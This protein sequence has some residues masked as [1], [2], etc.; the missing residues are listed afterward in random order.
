MIC[1]QSTHRDHNFMKRLTTWPLVCGALALLAVGTA[2]AADPYYINDGVVDYPGNLA[3]PPTIDATN[4]I[5]NNSF[6]INFTSLSVIPPYYEMFDTVNYTNTGLMVANSGYHFD[7]QIGSTGTHLMAGSFFNSGTISCGSSTDTSDPLLGEFAL[8]GFDQCVVNATNI[9]NPG[10]IDVGGGGLIK[11]TGLN[12]DLSGSTLTVEG[13]PLVTGYGVYNVN[14][15]TWSPFFELNGANNTSG[16]FGVPPFNLF[17]TTATTYIDIQTTQ[18]GYNVIRAV[19]IQDTSTN[20][21]TS[22]YFEPLNF[23]GSGNAI[24]QW[25]GSYLNS[26]DGN[27]D[28]T[29]LYLSD[30]Y[31][32]GASTNVLPIITVPFNF[33]VSFSGI[34]LNLGPPASSGFSPV[35]LRGPVTNA[36]DFANI[37]LQPGGDTNTIPNYSVT[38]LPGRI[39]ITGATNLDLTLAQLTGLSYMSIQSPY[40]FNGSAGALIQTP[41]ADLNLGVT[42]GFL[43]VS[44]TMES[45]VPTWVGNIQA[46]NTRWLAVDPVTGATNDYRVLMVNSLLQPT[47][48]AQVQDL[49]LHGTN[50]IIISDTFNV[51]RTFT[52]DAQ[53][54]TVTTNPPGNGATS[55]EGEL[56]LNSPTIFWQSSV[57]N[58]RYL[59]NNGAIRMGNSANFGHPLLTNI[60]P[61]VAASGML[62][63]TGTNAVKKDKVTIGTIQYLFVG[64]LT[65]SVANEVLI[66]PGSFDGTVS[67]LIAAINATNGAGSS[68]STAT[69]ANPVAVAG[70]LINH[71]FTVTA[72]N[73]GTAGNTISTMFTPAT[74]SINLSWQG[75][76]DLYGGLGV[77]TNTVSFLYNTAFI[78]NGIF[79]DYGAMIYAGNFISSDFFSNSVGS[80][81]LQ[82]LTTT[83]TN[84]SLY[85]G[86]DVSI[87]ASNIVTSNL[88]M[89]AGRS[90]TLLATNILTD[91]GIT[92]G[93]MWVVGTNST[94]VGLNLPIKPA[95]GDLLGTVITLF[96]P[97][98][99]NVVN[100]WAGQDRGRSNAGYTNNEAIGQLIFDILPAINLG[101]DGAYTFKGTGTSNA[102]YVDCLVLK[103]DAA[104]GNATNNYN[105]PWLTIG[106]NMVIYYAQALIN[107]VSVAEAIDKQ[108]KLGANNGRLR[109]IYSYAGY[110]SSTNLVYSDGSTDTVN[111]A[112]AQSST[113]DS[114]SDG[115]PN[116]QDPTPFFVSSEVN[117]TAMVTNLPPKSVK[118]QWT[119]IPNA[120]NAIYYTTNLLGT[121]INWLAYTNFK[122]WYYGN[123]VAHTN[124]AHINSFVS[125]QAYINNAS[126][127]DNS[128]QTNVWLYD[129]I[130]NVPHYYK[131]VV[132]PWLNYPE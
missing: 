33:Q 81:V 107:G 15:N 53:N 40:Q 12:V 64:I 11:L 72:L 1:T 62:V 132:S 92:N 66:V 38:N 54:L 112:L 80:F 91:S 4:F 6:T 3:Y 90:L 27:T 77:T 87:T 131:V 13:S 59:T 60:Y 97:T 104:K 94:G 83:L 78:N 114:D 30:D 89:Q 120:T 43:S 37:V 50:S 103:D 105:F 17:Q 7:T 41:Y 9:V 122:N 8:L 99:R 55:L 68:Y 29:Y 70:P 5:N 36:F 28:T 35:F 75:H 100:T 124:S 123:N 76:G 2:G 21:A 117:L 116:S 118:L 119:T 51:M 85:A 23:L 25:A 73:T 115:L 88:V 113:I 98:N 61:P 18:P 74:T 39:Q 31:V 32:L 16:F 96:A 71:G 67:N 10:L 125:P 57:P 128:Q 42:N 127:P 63:E 34:P 44:N 46:W 45:A 48:A 95:S 86:G 126:L 19:F 130:T 56:N 108:S 111:T 82:S 106:T 52:A 129:T 58:L 14:T 47:T 109:W 79:S 20:M 84:G 69:R 102:L 121:N 24:I 22:V 101:H 65:N 93:N 26:V 110:Y 49:I